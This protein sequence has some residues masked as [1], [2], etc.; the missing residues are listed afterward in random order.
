MEGRIK[1]KWS[2]IIKMGSHVTSFKRDLIIWYQI[3][4]TAIRDLMTLPWV[5]M[6]IITNS[7]HDMRNAIVS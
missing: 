6:T 4:S 7:A 1:E 3:E 5:T 2:I